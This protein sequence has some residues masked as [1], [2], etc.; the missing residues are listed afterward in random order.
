MTRNLKRRII[1][2]ITSLAMVFSFGAA[3]ALDAYNS[4]ISEPQSVKLNYDSIEEL[5][6]GGKIYVYNVDGVVSK[7]PVPPEGFKPL[8][9]T[10]EQLETYGFPPRP[11]K[12]N[13]EDYNCW[14]EQMG[15]YKSTAIPEIE[16]KHTIEDTNENEGI[17]P[18]SSVAGMY[19]PIAG[20]DAEI[21]GQEFFTQLQ[22][23]YIQPEIT[24]ISGTCFNQYWIGFGN[25]YNRQRIRVGTQSINLNSASAFVEFRTISGK[26]TEFQIQNFSVNAGDK[27]H[28]YVSFQKASNTLNYFIANNTNGQMTSNTI[29]NL[30]SSEFFNGSCA[31]W[32][33]ERVKKGSDSYYNFGKFSSIQFKNC[34]AM[35][36]TSN[37]WTDLGSLSKINKLSIYNY[38]SRNNICVASPLLGSSFTCIW[39]NFV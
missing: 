30:T 2:S 33:V 8:D 22:T 4:D 31:S 7:F 9:A 35:L 28:I 17:S 21:V 10:D 36:N 13:V 38:E 27:I 12:D 6:D 5:P 18:Q 37:T 29:E 34:K 16:V 20:Y 26:G 32:V 15:Y 25:P 14:V 3:N 39:T 1:S 19:Q 11:D 23:D 24:A